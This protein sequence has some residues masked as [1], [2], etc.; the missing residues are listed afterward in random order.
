MNSDAHLSLE[1]NE[2]NISFIDF[3]SFCLHHL[4]Y[5][6]P[7]DKLFF[8]WNYDALFSPKFV[9]FFPR[10]KM[11]YCRSRNLSSFIVVNKE[12]LGA[13]RSDLRGQNRGQIQNQRKI[14]YEIG[15]SQLWRWPFKNRW[16]S[17]MKANAIRFNFFWVTSK[18]INANWDLFNFPT[19]LETSSIS[20]GC[21]YCSQ[22]VNRLPIGESNHIIIK[23][24]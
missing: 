8:S 20:K 23:D 2:K 21:Y 18:S 17:L 4:C 14:L 15:L 12:I 10:R 1:V 7:S 22:G 13:P 16:Y 9:V 5:G 19:T 24:F 3:T 11:K 6:I